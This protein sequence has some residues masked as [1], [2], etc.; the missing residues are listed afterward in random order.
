VGQFRVGDLGQLYAGFNTWGQRGAAANPQQLNRYSYVLNNPVRNV[1]PT[2]HVNGDG[3]DKPMGGV[4]PGGM[5][6][7]GGGVG[8]LGGNSQ[9]T[10][11][12]LSSLKTARNA[13]GVAGESLP[14]PGSPTYASDGTE[15]TGSPMASSSR[16]TVDAVKEAHQLIQDM[17]EIPDEL[18]ASQIK[19]NHAEP[20]AAAQNPDA[21][22]FGVSK[23][24]CDRCM[25]FFRRYAQYRDNSIAVSTPIQDYIFRNDGSFIPI[26]GPK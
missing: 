25:S 2:G 14:Y 22:S 4:S 19:A 20:Q 17:K 18:S 13:R 3:E 8:G 1:D 12:E 11:T 21:R 15:I 9:L 23:D 26:Q 16:V 7:S 24:L 5:G 6:G 10:E